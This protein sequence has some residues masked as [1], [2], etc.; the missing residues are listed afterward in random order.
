LNFL[1][2]VGVNRMFVE[3]ASPYSILPRR[4]V[5]QELL[6]SRRPFFRS[7]FQRVLPGRFVVINA[8]SAA[9]NGDLFVGEWLSPK[10]DP[11]IMAL[12]APG[13]ILQERKKPSAERL[14]STG[15]S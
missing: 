7:E 1:P 6:E 14:P 2:E 12:W 8:A 3:G 10:L 15:N 9:L 11:E 13:M 5:N 4:M